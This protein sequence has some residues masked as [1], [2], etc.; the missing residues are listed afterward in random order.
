MAGKKDITALVELVAETPGW[1]VDATT[2]G[3]HKCI[4]KTTGQT[5]IIPNTPSDH[6]TFSNAKSQLRLSGW[7]E[8]AA[9][10]ASEEKRA[11]RMALDKAK[12]DA[13]MAAAEDRIE[14]ELAK[15]ETEAAAK[16][17]LPVT[18][19]F[20]VPVLTVAPKAPDIIVPKVPDIITVKETSMAA[21]QPQTGTEGKFDWSKFT[22]VHMYIDADWADKATTKG[23]CAQ[24]DVYDSNVDKFVKDMERGLFYPNP[25]DCIVFDE[26][27]C[28]VNGQ[29]RLYGL[30]D[31]D[32][33]KIAEHYP[34]GLEVFVI[35]GFPSAYAHIFDHGRSRT[36]KDDLDVRGRRD[37]GSGGSAALRLAMNLDSGEAPSGWNKAIWTGHDFDVAAAGRYKNLPE[38]TRLAKVVYKDA[39][40]NKTVC[41]VTAY[42]IDRENPGGAPEGSE[43]GGSN[44]DFWT[45]VRFKAALSPDDPRAALY[46]FFTNLRKDKTKT[47]PV[48]VQLGHVLRQYANW[49]L[50]EQITVSAQNSDWAIPPVWVPGMRWINSELRHPKPRSGGKTG[51][52]GRSRAKTDD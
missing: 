43:H 32:P 34:D 37:F 6:R 22:S 52:T 8:N 48:H 47:V 17:V 49:Q 41:M 44:E 21:V 11:E 27:G 33:D 13:M 26:H 42:L 50:G 16:K 25:Q 46:K 18:N 5:V 23:P 10:I 19:P 4:N 7:D 35:Y 31:A 20:R 40:M 29:H 1:L 14:A 38:Y 28:C 9:R 24:R 45:G 12:A 51:S 2:A 3:H 30:M 36:V 39:G 15:A